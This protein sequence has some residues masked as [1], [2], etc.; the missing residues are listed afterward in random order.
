MARRRRSPE[1]EPILHKTGATMTCR[2][3]RD[4]AGQV[5]A[6]VCGAR[7]RRICDICDRPAS[8]PPEHLRDGTRFDGCSR[9]RGR[10]VM[11]RRRRVLGQPPL[12]SEWCR[13]AETRIRE[14]LAGIRG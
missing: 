10:V 8:G 11:A 4:D 2:T 14:S 6:I 3:Y 1:S 5:V 7:P 12:D 9:C 13:L